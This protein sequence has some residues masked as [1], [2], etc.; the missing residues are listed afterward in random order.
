VAL[1]G[2]V[3]STATPATA[4]NASAIK[5]VRQERKGSCHAYMW[6]KN[7][8]AHRYYTKLNMLN[9]GPT[10]GC[11][12]W[13]ERKHNRK[14]TRVTKIYK[15][16]VHRSEQSGWHWDGSGYQSRV[17]MGV[18]WAPGPH[19]GNQPL[20][21]LVTVARRAP[22]SLGH[23][24]RAAA[25]GEQERDRRQERAESPAPRLSVRMQAWARRRCTPPGVPT[26]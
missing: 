16:R 13:M 26:P 18:H 25:R 7:T 8:G 20:Q 15:V 1:F 17:C 3:A 19:L 22:H 9:P 24:P 12:A 23:M 5:T 11:Y 6:A 2:I 14:I 4:A 10:T 21:A